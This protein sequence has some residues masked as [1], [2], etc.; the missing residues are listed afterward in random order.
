[1][2][3]GTKRGGLPE[4]DEHIRKRKKLVGDEDMEEMYGGSI[5]GDILNHCY[6]CKTCGKLSYYRKYRLNKS[7]DNDG[8]EDDEEY[9]SQSEGDEDESE[10]REDQS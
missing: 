6:K 1:M 5:K 2:D 7:E 10:G 3:R 8:D 9:D 4:S